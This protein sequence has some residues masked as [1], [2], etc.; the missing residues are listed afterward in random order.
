MCEF[1][2]FL[3]FVRVVL[4]WLLFSICVVVCLAACL[5]CVCVA[6]NS[7]SPSSQAN[8]S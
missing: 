5:V 4:F 6:V 3:F 8:E 7:D 2:D 1:I